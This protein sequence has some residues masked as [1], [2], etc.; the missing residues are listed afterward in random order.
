MYINIIQLA[1]SLGVSEGMIEDWIRLEGLP[2]IRDG[3]RMS[4]DRAQVIEWA[5]ERGISSKAGFLAAG[6]RPSGQTSRLADFLRLG[7]IWR[8][9]KSDHVSRLLEKIVSGLPGMGP[10]IIRL[11]SERIN[12]PRGMNWAQV[13]EGVA[14]PHLRVPVA[15]G[16]NRGVL[17]I[18]ILCEPASLPQPPPDHVPVKYMFFFIAPSPRVHLE[19]TGHLSS[20]LLHGRLR[21]LLAE[22]ASDE[23]IFSALSEPP[24]RAARKKD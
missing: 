5:G 9:V 21:A 19:M 12:T 4:F 10:E 16:H 11:L 20:H 1:E 24:P 7:G 13:G 18:L 22:N 3:A 2:C 17:A 8:N 23:A 14:M 15:L 6:V